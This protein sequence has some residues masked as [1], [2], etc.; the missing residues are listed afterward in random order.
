MREKNNHVDSNNR[1]VTLRALTYGLRTKKLRT[2]KASFKIKTVQ[3]LVQA[4]RDV[5]YKGMSATARIIQLARTLDRYLALSQGGKC[6][7][8]YIW[9][10]G[11]GENVRGKTRTMK[12][13]SM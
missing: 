13:G 10:D 9:I 7:A 6:L 8:T 5:N 11:T 12:S 2:Y 4:R 3:S 1:N